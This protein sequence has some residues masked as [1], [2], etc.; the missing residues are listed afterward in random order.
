VETFVEY[1]KGQ[2]TTGVFENALCKGFDY[3]NILRHVDTVNKVIIKRQNRDSFLTIPSGISN[4]DLVIS[5]L[6]VKCTFCN[7]SF[8]QGFS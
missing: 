3:A 5:N 2:Y 1:S 8:T 6:A 7:K 4:K